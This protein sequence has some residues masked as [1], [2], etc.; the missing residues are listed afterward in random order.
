M[1]TRKYMY[2]DQAKFKYDEM[3]SFLLSIDSS[4]SEN[5]RL[6]WWSRAFEMI[7][8]FTTEELKK[9]NVDSFMTESMAVGHRD[10]LK[11]YTITGL[12]HKL[13]KP[14]T[15]P[16]INKSRYCEMVNMQIKP[17]V[18]FNPFKVTLIS[19]GELNSN[20]GSDYIVVNKYGFVE[21]FTTG[22]GKILGKHLH[23]GFQ[24]KLPLI[25]FCPSLTSFLLANSP[26]FKNQ[27]SEL[28]EESMPDFKKTVDKFGS[29][30]FIEDFIWN[31][32]DESQL[33]N[34]PNVLTE[35]TFLQ[36]THVIQEFMH[37]QVGKINGSKT[38]S[39]VTMRITKQS[40][41]SPENIYFFIE[42]INIKHYQDI[43]KSTSR[44][45]KSV[46]LKW[47]MKM[48][49]VESQF[50]ERFQKSLVLQEIR[51]AM[52]KNEMAKEIGSITEN[53]EARSQANLPRDNYILPT[54]NNKLMQ[55]VTQV[56][57]LL[58]FMKLMK[59][60]EYGKTDFD[61]EA[62]EESNESASFM[63]NS[64]LDGSEERD[65]AEKNLHYKSTFLIPDRETIAHKNY[66]IL[67]LFLLSRFLFYSIFLIAVFTLSITVN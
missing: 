63:M 45:T 59:T 25:Y 53:L 4:P 6:V 40:T 20:F 57:K 33:V 66:F 5:G 34:M 67:K 27:F 32:F 50:D 18:L 60:D 42:F 41:S 37:E 7:M 28:D 29:E 47:L 58:K 44:L 21:T 52:K 11:K 51:T 48:G 65:I 62:N 9:M 8:D 19:Y 49:S 46:A 43:L 30:V 23:M 16:F 35:S 26:L 13:Y 55:K 54:K 64:Q 39:L 15:I 14:F 56:V 61:E 10:S 36:Q 12:S 38:T 24:E 31:S 3:G 17:F 1:I 22:F 2:C